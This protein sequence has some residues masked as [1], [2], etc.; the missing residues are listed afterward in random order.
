MSD[1]DAFS[2]GAKDMFTEGKVITVLISD[3]RQQKVRVEDADNAFELTSVILPKGAMAGVPDVALR[4]W[5]RNRTTH[6][7]GFKV[8][9]KDRLVATAWVPKP[10]VTAAEFVSH[11]RRLAREADLFENQLTGA[12]RE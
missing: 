4:A 5:R 11:V 3:G 7:V 8:D 10:G 12:D 2:R 6:L 1:W 9:Q